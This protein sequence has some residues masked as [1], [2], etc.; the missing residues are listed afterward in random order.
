MKQLKK[1]ARVSGQAGA[2]PPRTPG[3][4]ARRRTARWHAPVAALH[5]A[6][7]PA[8]AGAQVV[9]PPRHDT[10]SPTGVSYKNGAFNWSE[11]DL[12]IGGDDGLTFGRTYISSSADGFSPG[13]LFSTLSIIRVA[14]VPR[15]PNV[16][17]P[18][19]HLE[20]WVYHVTIGDRSY[21]FA[22]GAR[23]SVTGAPQRGGTYQSVENNGATLVYTGDATSG[24][25][26]LTDR[27]GSVITFDGWINSRIASWVRPDGT[28][29]DY[30][31]GATQVI[32]SSRGY[33]VI[34]E[35]KQKACVVNLA[36]TYV[37]P[38][39]GSTC[40]TGAEAVVYEYSPAPAAPS[41][42]VL[43]SATKAGA[44]TNY[45][46]VGAN[47]LGCIKAPGQSVCRISNVYGACP[48]DEND[49]ETRFTRRYRDPVLSQRT[50]TGETYSYSYGTS[51]MNLC[52]YS[53]AETKTANVSDTSEGDTTVTTNT[54]A[55]TRVVTNTAA[56]PTLISDPLMRETKA[57]YNGNGYLDVALSQ[58][59]NEIRPEKDRTDYNY[60]ERGNITSQVI[61][62]KPGSAE[63]GQTQTSTATFPP[64]CENSK[65]CNRPTSV[66]DARNATTDYTYDPNHG[67]VLTETRPAG[68]SGIRPVV[69]KSYAQ[70]SAW[71][72]N[73]GAGYER[74]GAP[75]W[76][77]TGERTCRTTATAGDACAGGAADEV[78][79]SYEY[80]ADAGPNN[81]ML[82]G[83]AITADG[84]TR[85]TCYGYDSQ[86][87]RIWETKPRAASGICS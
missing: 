4:V 17:A 43:T 50:G 69:R 79:T 48:V 28:R 86:G 81:L 58:L 32:R 83:V 3:A 11:Q 20:R 23:N 42:E 53:T 16:Q 62:A 30:F 87:N 57:E 80:G 65:T 22:G 38:Q 66:T 10:R 84:T 25:F 85:R 40:P 26:T 41:M 59:M 6:L 73:A 49:A 61:T 13:W 55:Q 82:R 21:A 67:G 27:D 56:L 37:A 44:T 60:D 76:L 63:N 2:T 39:A 68:E 35:G 45:E 33:A 54:N 29:L 8:L 9:A 46:Y 72:L 14:K 47:H 1:T 75:I 31:N 5:L 78:V 71:I 18:P 24:Y 15:H 52:D 51:W 36:R 7:L 19:P 64:T 12:S 74:A 70:R 34:V 77:L